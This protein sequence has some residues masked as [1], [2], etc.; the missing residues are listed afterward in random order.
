MTIEAL[1]ADILAE[2]RQIRIDADSRY[3]EEKAASEAHVLESRKAMKETLDRGRRLE[4]RYP[5]AGES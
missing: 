3:K 5:P 1:L 2:L 4:L